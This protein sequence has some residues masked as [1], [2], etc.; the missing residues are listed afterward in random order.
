MQYSKWND[1]PTSSV[2][3]RRAAYCIAK[4]QPKHGWPPLHTVLARSLFRPSL[5]NKHG[6]CVS[7]SSHCTESKAKMSLVWSMPYCV[8]WSQ[9]LLS[10]VEQSGRIV[11]LIL[12]AESSSSCPASANALVVVY[13]CVSVLHNAYFSFD[14][15]KIHAPNCPIFKICFDFWCLCL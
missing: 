8:W 9:R 13:V 10:W 7:E 15:V 14:R 6:R 1:S 12:L 3:F 4:Q 5:I 11:A 2:A